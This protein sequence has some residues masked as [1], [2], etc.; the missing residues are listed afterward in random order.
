MTTIAAVAY[1]LWVVIG[2]VLAY[3]AIR[4]KTK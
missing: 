3:A 4:R 2:T 1:L